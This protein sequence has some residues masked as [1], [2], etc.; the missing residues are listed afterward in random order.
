MLAR[1]G[2]VEIVQPGRDRL[3]RQGVA[4]A[5]PGSCGI[6]QHEGSARPQQV[7]RHARGIEA[8]H[9]DVAPRPGIAQPSRKG[10]GPRR[11]ARRD[12]HPEPRGAQ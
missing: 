1:I 3:S 8:E 12:H 10:L 4:G 9:D 6:H 2:E 11:V 7:G 5:L